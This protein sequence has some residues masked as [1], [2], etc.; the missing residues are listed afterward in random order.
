MG[1]AW[2][3]RERPAQWE[4]LRAAISDWA[5]VGALACAERQRQ[6]RTRPRLAVREQCEHRRMRLVRG[7]GEYSHIA[8][9]AGYQ[10]KAVLGCVDAGEQPKYFAQTADFDA[11]PRTMRFIDKL[12][13]KRLRE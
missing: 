9:A 4:A 11:Q 1:L 5:F 8:G 10:R 6:R 2:L 13:A 12:R 3:R 7:R